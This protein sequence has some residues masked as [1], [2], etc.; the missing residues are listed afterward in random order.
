MGCS[1]SLIVRGPSRMST[2]SAT[3]SGRTLRMPCCA[4][5][6][7]QAASTHVWPSPLSHCV[8]GRFGRPRCRVLGE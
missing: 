6:C 8:R 2:G 4:S 5:T 7:A 1:G 3:R